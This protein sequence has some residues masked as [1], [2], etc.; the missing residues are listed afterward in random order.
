LEALREK[1]GQAGESTHRIAEI[2]WLAGQSIKVGRLAGFSSALPDRKLSERDETLEVSM[3]DRAVNAG[4]F[5][6]V[7]NC[8]LGLVHIEVEQ[9]PPTGPILQRADR[10]F[11]LVCV[12]LAH[13]AS[14]SAHVGGQTNRPTLALLPT[15]A[16]GP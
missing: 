4:G 5:G 15:Q 12:V 3:C 1:A 7:V 16:I 13:A 9:D 10:T 14:L 6:R 11:D 2:D 8:P